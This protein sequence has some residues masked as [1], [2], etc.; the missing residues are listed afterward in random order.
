MAVPV[1]NIVIEKGTTFESTYVVKNPDGSVFSLVNQTA[2]AKIKK[3]PSATSSSSFSTSITTGVGEIRISMASSIT[4]NLSSGRNYYDVIITNNNNG[5][6]TKV[7]EGTALV[8]DTL[9]S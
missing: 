7:F 2:T 9:S 1:V 3:H 8:R 4:S 5:K 6:V